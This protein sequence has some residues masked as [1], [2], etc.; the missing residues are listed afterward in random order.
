MYKSVEENG[1]RSIREDPSRVPTIEHLSRHILYSASLARGSAIPKAA[2]ATT[3]HLTAASILNQAWQSNDL[4]P[5]HTALV[6]AQ[7][8]A[9][10][11]G[12]MFQGRRARR[13]SRSRSGLGCLALGTPSSCLCSWGISNREAEAGADDRRDPGGTSRNWMKDQ[14]E[15]AVEAKPC[16]VP[17]SMGVGTCRV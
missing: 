15:V 2:V 4:L 8:R 3:S 17:R 13:H 6:V 10:G 1:N 9:G 7:L 11:S 16:C 5:N 14:D 12:G